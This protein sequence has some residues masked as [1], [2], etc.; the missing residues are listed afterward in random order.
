MGADRAAV[1]ATPPIQ[2]GRPP[3]DAQPPGAGRD[4]V[5]TPDRG[6]LAGLARQVPQPVHLLAALAAV[7]RAGCLAGDLAQVL[8]RPG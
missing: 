2:E 6:T 4:L 8:G 7:G 5:G 3:V 1:A